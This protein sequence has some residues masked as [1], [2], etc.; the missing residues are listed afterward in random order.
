M[1]DSRAGPPPLAPPRIIKSFLHRKLAS[2]SSLEK[3]ASLE[4][5]G[6]E[7]ESLEK[8]ASLEKERFLDRA[9]FKGSL[10]VDNYSSQTARKSTIMYYKK[11]IMY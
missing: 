11:K 6:L 8:A 3:A 2:S 4:K 5:E 9:F 7:K 1:T 10:Q